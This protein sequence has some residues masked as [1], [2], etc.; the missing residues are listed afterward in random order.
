MKRQQPNQE[1]GKRDGY[2]DAGEKVEYGLDS[3][4]NV[5]HG[6][7]QARPH[8]RSHQRRDEHCADDYRR[9]AF[10]QSERSDAGGKK[11]LQPVAQTVD[12]GGRENL[13]VDLRLGAP[14]N[15]KPRLKT[16]RGG[17]GG[18]NFLGAGQRAHYAPAQAGHQ[19]VLM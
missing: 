6:E 14:R 9:T 8:D 2:R 5:A 17:M 19:R 13:F 1:A 10:D 18:A 4:V 15:A 3:Q 7:R 11:D 12:R 16:Q